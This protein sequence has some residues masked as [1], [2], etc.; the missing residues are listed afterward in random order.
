MERISI[1]KEGF[2][3]VRRS[4][5]LA[6]LHHGCEWEDVFTEDDVAAHKV[7]FGL[8]VEQFP[9]F[10]TKGITHKQTPPSLGENLSLIFLL[11]AKHK[12]PNTLI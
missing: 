7:F 5:G 1:V 2:N 11:C 12:V 6:R 9:S 10:L 8:K 4:G 3:E